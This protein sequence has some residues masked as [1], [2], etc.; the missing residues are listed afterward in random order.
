MEDDGVSLATAHGGPRRLGQRSSRLGCSRPTRLDMVGA[1]RF[2]GLW[3]RPGRELFAPL[4]PL[5]EAVVPEVP[6][7]LPFDQSSLLEGWE[8]PPAVVAKFQ[9]LKRRQK[10]ECTHG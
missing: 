10:R 6:A 2:Y 8:A 3:V 5:A 9:E 4:L 1:H 7:L